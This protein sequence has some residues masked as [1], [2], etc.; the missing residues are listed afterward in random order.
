MCLYHI[1]WSKK[2]KILITNRDFDE[3]ASS[4][5]PGWC[6]CGSESQ[7]LPPRLSSSQAHDW[8]DSLTGHTLNSHETGEMSSNC[9][10]FFSSKLLQLNWRAVWKAHEP[11]GRVTK[12]R[13]T[14]QTSAPGPAS[15]FCVLDV[16]G[17][18]VFQLQPV[19]TSFAG[20][21]LVQKHINMGTTAHKDYLPRLCSDGEAVHL[22]YTTD[23]SRVY[24]QEE[25]KS[26]EVNAEVEWRSCG[27]RYNGGFFCP[28]LLISGFFQ[29]TDAVEFLIHSY[30][31]FVT[32]GS[33]PCNSTAQRVGYFGYFSEWFVIIKDTFFPA[34]CFG[35]T[36]IWKG[37]YPHFRTS[38]DHTDWIQYLQPAHVNLHNC[39]FQTNFDQIKPSEPPFLCWLFDWL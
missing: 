35:W 34:D 3:E 8:C 12:W 23:N 9:D 1:G 30:P 19:R 39:F 37:D 2:A 10:F 27:K 32:V 36:A 17:N 20:V 4:L 5:L 13:M 28:P 29:L 33:L 15:D 24:H 14:V 11:D 25:L 21:K 6:C 16:P 18:K 38:V 31:K 26:L 22:Y 7:R